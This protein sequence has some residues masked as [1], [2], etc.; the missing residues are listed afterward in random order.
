MTSR[1]SKRAIFSRLDE[2]REII[3]NNHE[4]RQ[5]F[6]PQFRQAAT[7]LENNVL[8]ESGLAGR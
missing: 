8:S 3:R 2:K 5:D 1:R 6:S 4:L 7:L